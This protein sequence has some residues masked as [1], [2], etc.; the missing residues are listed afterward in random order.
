MFTLNEYI[1]ILVDH[2][3]EYRLSHGPR[4]QEVLD[5]IRDDIAAQTVGKLTEEEVEG[6]D[7]VSWLIYIQIP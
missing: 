7:Q 1:P 4:R 5:E 6:L 2:E 3:V